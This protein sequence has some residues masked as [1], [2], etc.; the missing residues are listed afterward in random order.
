MYSMTWETIECAV[1]VLGS[2]GAGLCAAIHMTDAP[3][4]PSVVIAVKGLYGKSG[5]TRMVQGGYNAVLHKEDSLKAHF[6]DTLKGGQ[7]IN[8]QEL[9]WRL[10]S[11]A[12]GRVLELENRAGCL[13]DRN[14]DGTIHQKPFAGQSF[15]KYS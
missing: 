14:L 13:F 7:W 6:L 4:P 9:A 2:G 15:D 11:E 8:N 5:C 12:P 10:I 3:L 1:L